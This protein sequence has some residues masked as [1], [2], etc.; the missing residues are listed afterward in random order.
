MKFCPNCGNKLQ[1]EDKFCEKCG[2]NLMQESQNDLNMSSIKENTNKVK[3]QLEKELKKTTTQIQNKL[4]SIDMSWLKQENHKW[5]TIGTVLVLIIIILF[6]G[7]VRHNGSSVIVPKNITF[8]KENKGTRIWFTADSDTKNSKVS[9]IIK[10]TGDKATEY[11]I[12]D[13]SITLGKLSKLNNRQI[14]KLANKQNKKCFTHIVKDWYTSDLPVIKYSCFDQYKGKDGVYTLNIWDGGNKGSTFDSAGNVIRNY[15]H[16]VND[17]IDDSTLN[18]TLYSTDASENDNKTK[19]MLKA[20]QN[21]LDSTTYQKQRTA[22]IYTKNKTDSSGNKVTSEFLSIPTTTYCDT[23]VCQKNFLNICK[24]NPWIV[25]NLIAYNKSMDSEEEMLDHSPQNNN[26]KFNKYILPI[27]SSKSFQREV[28]KNVFSRR[29]TWDHYNLN[30]SISFDIYKSRFIGY[31]WTDGK[32]S[33]VLV[34]KAQNHKQQAAFPKP[35]N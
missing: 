18:L 24:N 32:Y 27:F 29:K 6:V 12:Y 19:I 28:T 8:S 4:K 9:E 1:P 22:K 31:D 33:G 26:K 20:F 7:H 2:Y 13:D 15:S 23:S 30:D 5:Y 21:A 35:S 17:N 14:L 34:T 25:K 10:Q 16:S 11:D 3:K